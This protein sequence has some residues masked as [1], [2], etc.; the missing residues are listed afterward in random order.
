MI[1]GVVLQLLGSIFLWVTAAKDPATIPS[2][3][4]V[5]L[6]NLLMK[7]VESSQILE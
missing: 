6:F 3:V 5:R 2:R 4:S 1:I 7:I